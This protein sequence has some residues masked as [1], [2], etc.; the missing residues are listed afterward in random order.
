MKTEI[1]DFIYGRGSNEPPD[2]VEYM[3]W[4]YQ[5]AVRSPDPSTQNGAVLITGT[6]NQPAFAHGWNRIPK[7]VEQNYSDREFKYANITHAEAAVI[8]QAAR[9]GY[10]TLDSTLVCPWAPCVP[11]A[12]DILDAGVAKLVVHGPRMGLIAP[13]GAPLM[14]RRANWGPNV[15]EAL[16]LLRG[17]CDVIVV[18]EPIPRAPSIRIGGKEWNPGG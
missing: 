2:Y 12:R 8:F 10:A 7:G 6:G 18:D 13:E 9:V 15:E 5:N 17:Y 16:E 11:C 1:P 14:D 3:R 4:A